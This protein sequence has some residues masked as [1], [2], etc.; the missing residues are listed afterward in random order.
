MDPVETF[1][2]GPSR[3]PEIWA[4]RQQD[5]SLRIQAGDPLLDGI[6]SPQRQKH[7]L[8]GDATG[9]GHLSGARVPDKSEFPPSW[10]ESEI[11]E[12]AADLA[13]NPGLKWEQIDGPGEGTIHSGY[14]GPKF[15]NSGKPVRYRIVDQAGNLPIVNGVTIRVIIQPDGEGVITA[16]P[17]SGQGVIRNPP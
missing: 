14:P 4:I 16:V 15:T 12:V 13:T 9:G 3:I 1:P 17:I 11:L 10:T 2:L 7:I 8:Y 6:I 5:P